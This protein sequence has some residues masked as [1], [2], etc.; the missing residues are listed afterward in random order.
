MLFLFVSFSY[1]KHSTKLS[2]R[3]IYSE[4]YL[5]IRPPYGMAVIS[6]KFFIPKAVTNRFCFLAQLS[7]T[8]P[9]TLYRKC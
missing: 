8:D 7:H 3:I 5:I 2:T 1:M 4:E 6:D 9:L